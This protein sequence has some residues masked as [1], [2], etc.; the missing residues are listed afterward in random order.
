MS[1]NKTAFLTKQQRE[2]L[3][4]LSTEIFGV[5]S[6]YQK[7]F[8]YDE[9]VGIKQIQLIKKEDGSTEEKEVTVP[10]TLN[11]SKIKVRKYRTYEEVLSMLKEYK[12]QKETA[13]KAFEKQQEEEKK[14][15]ETETQLNS[16]Q[17]EAGGTSLV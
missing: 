7:L 11:G 14:Q 8:E 15:K 4:D 1:E 16:I 13:I 10:K 12:T 5:S 17:E 2:E 6:K 3:K 9:Y